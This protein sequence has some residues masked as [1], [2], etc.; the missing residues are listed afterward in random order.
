M[1]ELD[2]IDTLKIIREDVGNKNRDGVIIVLTANAIAGCRE[3]YLEYGFD[4]YFSKPILAD[5]FEEL[6]IKYLPQEKV[7][8]SDS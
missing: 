3:M 4:D 6:L 5:D 1:P 2:G 7:K 8:W